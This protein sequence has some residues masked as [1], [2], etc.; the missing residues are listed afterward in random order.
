MEMTFTCHVIRMRGVRNAY[1]I[2]VGT[3]QGKRTSER[4]RHWWKNNIKIEIK[5]II[6]GKDWIHVQG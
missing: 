5:K 3:C 6:R 2:S 1:N 4:A